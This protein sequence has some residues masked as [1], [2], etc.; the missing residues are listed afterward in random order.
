M[1]ITTEWLILGQ[2]AQVTVQGEISIADIQAFDAQRLTMLDAAGHPV[3]WII[4]LQ[5]PLAFEPHIQSLRNLKAFQHPRL[6]WHVLVGHPPRGRYFI[7]SV[8]TQLFKIRIRRVESVAEG[9]QLLVNIEGN[10]QIHDIRRVLD[11]L[12]A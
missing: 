2:V 12:K 8:M 9:L 1:A 3:H 7:I 6:G 11:A 10:L 4:H 5:D